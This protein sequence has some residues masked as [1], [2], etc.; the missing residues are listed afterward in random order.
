M[1]EL[2]LAGSEANAAKGRA[3][4]ACLQSEVAERETK[5][6]EGAKKDRCS[7]GRADRQGRSDRGLK[8]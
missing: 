1:A 4:V 5:Q 2:T 7:L 8:S 6:A 3:T